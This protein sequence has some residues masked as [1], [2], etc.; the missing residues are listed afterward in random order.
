[1]TARP[2]RDAHSASRAHG[3][4]DQSGAHSHTERSAPT[5]TTASGYTCS[6]FD[7][8][9]MSLSAVSVIANAL[10]LRRAKS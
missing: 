2:N 6:M 1:M 10:R 9:A 3:A 5:K 7:A 4:H 8:A